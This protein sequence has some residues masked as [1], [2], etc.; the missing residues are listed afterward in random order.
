MRGMRTHC[1]QSEQCCV[2]SG[3]DAVMH[4]QKSK[5]C[6]TI[7]YKSCK[8]EIDREVVVVMPLPRQQEINDDGSTAYVGIDPSLLSSF[9]TTPWLP[10]TRGDR[11][12]AKQSR[13]PVAGAPPHARG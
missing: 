10:R 12:T 2:V 9:R 13:A 4:V 11:P 8:G 5:H 3:C 1:N 7:H 6:A